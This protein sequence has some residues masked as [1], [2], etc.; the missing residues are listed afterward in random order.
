MSNFKSRL[1]GF[2]L[3]Q[4]TEMAKRGKIRPIADGEWRMAEANL[5]CQISN[6]KWQMADSGWLMVN[7]KSQISNHEEEERWSIEGWEGRG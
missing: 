4:V 3:P 1:G 2:I 5:K 7:S 6:P